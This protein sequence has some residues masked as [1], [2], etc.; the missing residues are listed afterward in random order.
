[1]VWLEN[2]ANSVSFKNDWRETFTS[3]KS[4]RY[5]GYLKGVKHFGSAENLLS[6]GY[7]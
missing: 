4:F 1:M 6:T 3:C 2:S 7:V 5:C